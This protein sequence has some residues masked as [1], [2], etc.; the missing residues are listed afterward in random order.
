MGG[1]EKGGQVGVLFLMDGS[2]SKRRD[3]S[4]RNYQELLA[5][6]CALVLYAAFLTLMVV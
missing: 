6:D 4:Q 3:L 1:G 2:L 5:S